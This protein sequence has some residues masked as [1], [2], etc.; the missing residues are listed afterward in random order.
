ML[1]EINEVTEQ[2]SSGQTDTLKNVKKISGMIGKS[3]A[4]KTKK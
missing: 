3:S 4:K 2:N 1:S